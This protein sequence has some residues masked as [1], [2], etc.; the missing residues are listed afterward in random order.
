MFTADQLNALVDYTV[1]LAAGKA[2][3]P[4]PEY[5]LAPPEFKCSPQSSSETCG[6]N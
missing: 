6:G 3:I 1:A 2:E 4:P 5:P